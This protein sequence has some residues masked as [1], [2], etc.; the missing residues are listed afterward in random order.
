MKK[1]ILFYAS[2]KRKRMF[3]LQG[4]FRTDIKILKELGFDVHL[5]NKAIDFLKFWKYDIAFIYFFRYGL[6]PAV[7][8]K[9]FFKNVYF[10]G[11]IDNLDKN[12]S[13]KKDYL[14]QYI[15]FKL[16]NIF[17]D[18]TIIVSTSDIENIAKIYNGQIPKNIIKSFHVINFEKYKYSFETKKE[19]IITTICWMVK[20]E[21]VFRKGIDK[22]LEVFKLYLEH[23]PKFKL[24][25]I[26]PKGEG[27]IYIENMITKLGISDNVLLTGGITEYEKIRI[28]NS[29]KYYTQL[30]DYEGFGIASIEALASGN[31][32]IHSGKG[33][34]KDAVGRNGI[35]ISDITD[36]KSISDKINEVDSF[37]SLEERKELITKGIEYVEQNFKYDNRLNVFKDIIK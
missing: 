2:V 32:V 8:A 3:S 22:T 9:F 31:I 7:I 20:I 21:N 15:F 11:G 24:V 16:C 1:R 36:Y 13:K 12:F 26:G 28:L 6:F 27:S 5:S 17:S 19:D 10:T 14:I 37:F 29:S 25:I 23:N 34:L 33:G 30:S 18:T 4:F 35:L